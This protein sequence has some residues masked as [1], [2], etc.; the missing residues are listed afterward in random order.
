VEV[1]TLH[2]QR[3]PNPREY[4]IVRTPTKATTVKRQGITLL[5]VTSCARHLIQTT[6]KNTNQSKGPSGE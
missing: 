6:N 2:Y 1:L 4:Q 3:T 5:P